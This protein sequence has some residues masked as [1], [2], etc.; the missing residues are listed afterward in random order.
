MKK[1]HDSKSNGGIKIIIFVY[2]FISSCVMDAS[3]LAGGN[4]VNV[5]KNLA[6]KANVGKIQKQRDDGIK[7]QAGNA[8]N[9]KKYGGAMKRFIRYFGF[10]QPIRP[11]EQQQFRVDVR[12]GRI[13]QPSSSFT[14][15]KP[16]VPGEGASLRKE[17][18]PTG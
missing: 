2:K 8:Q 15:E 18:M 3:V 10:I 16:D 17:R 12:T 14:S 5:I 11:N 4:L 6:N 9:D 7:A 1:K 13:L